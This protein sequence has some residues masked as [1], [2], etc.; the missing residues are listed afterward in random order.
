MG[1]AVRCA[2][3]RETPENPKRLL[4]EP[5]RRCPGEVPDESGHLLPRDAGICHA[6]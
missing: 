5:L 6:G 4:A 3:D 1:S 2:A